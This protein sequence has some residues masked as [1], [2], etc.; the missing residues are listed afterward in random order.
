MGMKTN[1]RKQNLMRS[2]LRLTLTHNL[3]HKRLFG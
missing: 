2:P 1:W 3:G